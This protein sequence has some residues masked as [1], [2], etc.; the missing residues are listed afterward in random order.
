MVMSPAGLRAEKNCT[1]EAQQQ[2]KTTDTSRQR[3][4]SN[5][6]KIIKKGQK[7]VAGPRRA[8]DTKTD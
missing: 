1:G 4:T 3:V 8:S 6:L 7:L 5:C 2:L